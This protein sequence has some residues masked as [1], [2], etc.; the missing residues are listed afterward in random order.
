MNKHQLVE[1]LPILRQ[2]ST[3]MGIVGLIASFYGL[4]GGTLS[5]EQ[6]GHLSE[7]VLALVSI[8]AIVVQPKPA[9]GRYK[10][11]DFR[12]GDTY[13]DSNGVIHVFQEG[14]WKP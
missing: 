14:A 1:L 11:R 7:I 5:A 9:G 8:V 4:F 6:S 2:K 10:T 3:I 13:E 12:N